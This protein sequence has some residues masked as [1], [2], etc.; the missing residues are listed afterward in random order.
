MKPSTEG[1][2]GTKAGENETKSSTDG[3][4]AKCL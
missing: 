1:A 3:L 2:L 4:G